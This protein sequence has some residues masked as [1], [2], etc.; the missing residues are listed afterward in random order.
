MKRQP[1]FISLIVVIALLARI[2][3][4][5]RTIDDAYITFRYARNIL[6]GEGMVFNPGERVMGT[7]TPLY[8]GFLAI[9][10]WF[11]GGT[12]AQFPEISSWINALFDALTCILLWKLGSRANQPIAGTASALVW[13]IAPFSVTF[14]IGGL[15]TSLYIFLLVASVLCYQTAH[16]QAAWILCT[17]A[18]I[19]R[20]DALILIF[21]LGFHRL[22]TTFR[23]FPLKHWLREFY[24][25]FSIGFLWLAFA[26]IY[27]GS[28]IPHSILAKTYAY[29]LDPASALIRFLQHYATPFMDGNFL[30]GNFILAGLF[31]YP[32]LFLVGARKVTRQFPALLP[33]ALYPWLYLLVFA[34]QNPLVFRWYLTPPLPAYYFFILA[35]A[36]GLSRDVLN[37]AA[38]TIRLSST[39]QVFHA[40]SPA[41]IGLICLYPF[42]A[43]LSD[44]R[45]HP[46]HGPDRPA[47][48]MAYIELEGLYHQA[49]TFLNPRLTTASLLAAG[50]VGV[51][52]YDTPARILDTVGLNSPVTLNYYPADRALYTINYAIPPELILEQE[53]D[54]LVI[55]EVYGRNGL[56]A[57]TQFKR[58]YQLIHTF[59]TNIYGS[60]GMLVFEKIAA[61]N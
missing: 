26:L 58:K 15:E 45:T 28:P 35:G 55:L 53:P 44:W 20:P 5:A 37:W 6:A 4:G 14:A 22:I 13:A 39:R 51:L 9:T 3:P 25:A 47:P 50:D 21:L 61:E 33:F 8:T 46:D 27:F 56:L 7:S 24:P 42:S 59:P 23:K 36:I 31:L 49:A 38:S 10:G 54:F 18:L 34:I 11:L 48:D 1:L 57:D 52:G 17:L 19:T 41:L 12:Q 30:P 43:S 32:F 40:L 29:L 60:K 2:I 16:F